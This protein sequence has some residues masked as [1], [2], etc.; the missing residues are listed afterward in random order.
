MKKAF[1][2]CIFFMLALLGTLSGRVIHVYT[3]YKANPWKYTPP[4]ETCQEEL[5]LDFIIFG[6]AIILCIIAMIVLK[7][8]IKKREKQDSQEEKGE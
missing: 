2:Y 8:I 5:Q 4:Y 3:D 6:S 1:N 7:A